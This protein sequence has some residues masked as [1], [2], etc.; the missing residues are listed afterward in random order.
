MLL[1][2]V[3]ICGRAAAQ[4]DDASAEPSGDRGW[5]IELW[6]TP[7][8]RAQIAIWIEH[9]DGEFLATVGLTEAVALRGIGNRPGASQM[10]SGFRWPY[11]RREGVLPVW[12][13]RRLSAPGAQ[14]F[15]QVIFQDR[16]SE[17][18]AS[19]SSNDHT[20]DDYFCLSFDNSRSKKDALDAVSCASVFTSDKGRFMTEE[21]VAAGYAEPYEDP[22]T[23]EG[24]MRPLSLDALYPPRRDVEPCFAAS[25]YD[26]PD[27]AMY[28]EH[29]LGVMPELDAITMAT[30]RGPQNVLFPMPADAAHGEY[31]ACVEINVEGDHNDAFSE[32]KYPTPMTPGF[33]PTTKYGDVLAWDSW[34]QGFGYAYRGQPSVVYCVDFELGGEREQLRGTSVPTGSS[35][36]WDT[37]LDSYG[38]M[39]G[40][41]AMDDDP[42][43]HPGS[44][45]DRLRKQPD[46]DR[47]TV[48]VRPPVSCAT[49]M[50]PTA[51]GE[52]EA[53]IYP[54]QKHAHDYATLSFLASDDDHGIHR[55]EVRFSTAPITDEA[56]FMRG[57]PAKSASVVADEL[58]V[59]TDIAAGE[60]IDVDIGGLVPETH[61]YVGVRAVDICA[62]PGPIAVAEVTTEARVFT[63]VTP[64]FVATAAYGTPLA[65]EVGALRR[66]RDRY[67]M[68]NAPG[69]ALVHAYYQVGA[70]VAEMIAKRPQWRAAARE[71]LTPLVRLAKWLGDAG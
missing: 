65:E 61:Y 33:I 30:P 66:L 10:N 25:C 41:E 55:Y 46:G 39:S 17:G 44:G 54:Q 22:E 26:H 45:V 8:E 56:S 20:R 11:G 48:L 15:R 32:A 64:C 52:L 9:G 38:E 3:C 70:E 12:A 51:V 4:A 34:A 23:G 42:A 29:A 6:F 69:R 28:A 5:L 35:G 27:L 36:H 18:H 2:A 58:I 40:V 1:A 7:V 24:R 67:L 57:T 13:H 21:D 16:A 31:R 50:P 60:R 49:D 62:A 43:L 19:R 53:G 63:T 59:P 71:M 14:P 47:L 37:T 68:S